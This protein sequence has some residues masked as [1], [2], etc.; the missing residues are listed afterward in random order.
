MEFKHV[1]DNLTVKHMDA[2]RKQIQSLAYY[3]LDHCFWTYAML[4]KI[5]EWS[6]EIIYF[7][8]P[9]CFALISTR[10]MALDKLLLPPSSSFLQYK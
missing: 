2:L 4:R 7:R 10:G 9:I 8:S 1:F 5:S 3:V 6:Q